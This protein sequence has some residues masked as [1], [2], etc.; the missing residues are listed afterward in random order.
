[1]IE[2]AYENTWLYGTLD[3]PSFRLKCPSVL[4][5]R[6]QKLWKSYVKLR[7]LLANSPKVKQ[8]D[9]QKLAQRE[10]GI[11]PSSPMTNDDVLPVYLRLLLHHTFR[12]RWKDT[13]KKKITLHSPPHGSMLIDFFHL[14]VAKGP[15]VFLKKAS[16]LID[17]GNEYSFSKKLILKLPRLAFCH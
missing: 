1:M 15:Y 2:Q 4:F 17:V 5:L 6:Y 3:L 13:L 10:V 11:G 14:L 16:F 9:K 12:I 7:H 8:T